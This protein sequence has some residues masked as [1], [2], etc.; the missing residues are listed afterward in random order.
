MY[1]ESAQGNTEQYF[2]EVKTAR[3]REYVKQIRNQAGKKTSKIKRSER[4]SKGAV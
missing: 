2:V 1:Q 4:E 3:C